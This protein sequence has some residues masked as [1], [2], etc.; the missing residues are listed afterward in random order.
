MPIVSID[1]LK[2]LCSTKDINHV[3]SA[4]YAEGN[5]EVERFFRKRDDTIDSIFKEA[6]P[7]KR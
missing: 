4:L 1:K 3:M 7:S 6:N 5:K 2:V